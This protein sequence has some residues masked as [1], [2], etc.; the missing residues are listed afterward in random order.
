MT[1]LALLLFA[2]A[3]VHTFVVYRYGAG[4]NNMPFLIFAGLDLVLAI[5]VFLAWPYAL[6]ATL[7]LSAV[8]LVGLTLTFRKPQ[9]DKTPDYLIWALDAAI[10]VVAAYL[11]F[12]AGAPAATGA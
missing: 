12:F 8:G 9:R 4:G 7:I 10:V 1:L 5:V 2:N 3:A 6:W 11:L